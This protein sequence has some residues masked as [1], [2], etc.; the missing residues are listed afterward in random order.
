MTGILVGL[1]FALIA[2]KRK[3]ILWVFIA[4]LTLNL[5]EFIYIT[6]KN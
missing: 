6:I 4:H 5:I 3:N 1:P 2:V